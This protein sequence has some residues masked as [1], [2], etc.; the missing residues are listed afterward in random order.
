[1]SIKKVTFL[2][3]AILFIGISVIL[4]IFRSLN[5]A[6]IDVVAVNDITQSLAEHWGSQEQSEL[7]SRQYGLE[8]TVLD[9]RGDLVGA[10][11]RGLSENIDS[12]IHNR[13]TIVDITRNGTV[14]GKVIIFNNTSELWEK[15]RNDLLVFFGVMIIFITLFC[16]IYA[17]YID[18]SIFRPFRKL[19]AFA[20]H[21]A[22]GKL[23]MPLEMEKGNG[24]GAFAESFDLMREELAKARENE[25]MANQS[26]KELVASLSHDIKTPVASIKAVSEVMI[27]NSVIEDDINQLEVINS[28]A[29]QINTLITNLFNATLE[30]LQELNVT[31]T[32]ESSTVLGDLI[33]NVDYYNRAVV[34]SIPEC[35][36]LIDLLRLLQVVDNVI[37]NSYKYAGTSIGVSAS[38]KGQ[39]LEIEFKDYGQG[40]SPEEIPLL[41]N[42][43]YRAKNSVGKSGTGLGLYISQY[44]MNK[45]SGDINCRN[46]DGGFVVILRLHIA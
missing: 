35:I 44:L 25:R 19:Q 24:F 34:S 6:G 5:E 30:E 32:E 28:K 33:Q 18:R 40:V 37:S 22:E 46:M 23:D 4:F 10:T 29:D 38:I 14:L 39:Y 36:V 21:V 13:D 2:A 7:P 3:V 15:Y 41:F 9:S 12:A 27:L 43:F 16:L 31:V 42:K 20:R 8:Y 11:R 26:K 17:V 45:M 1:M